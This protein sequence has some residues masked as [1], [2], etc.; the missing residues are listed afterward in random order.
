MSAEITERIFAISDLHQGEGVKSPLEDFKHHP[1]GR[2]INDTLFD[3]T[4]DHVFMDFVLWII[5]TSGEKTKNRLKLLGDT[6]DPLAVKL[7]GKSVVI[8]YEPLDL[9]KFRKICRGHREFFR[10]LRYFCSHENCTLEVHPGNHDMFLWWPRVQAEF[11]KLVSPDHPERV[12]FMH[13]ELDRGIYYWHGNNEP[14]DRFDPKKAIIRAA[15]LQDFLKNED[16]LELLLKGKIPRREVMDVPQGHY[17]TAWLENPL[18]EADYLIGRMHIHAFVWTDAFSHIF[19]RAWYRRRLFPAIALY[20]LLKTLL[21]HSLSMFTFWHTKTKSDFWKIMRVV[22]WT[23]TGAIVGHSARD[24][25]VKKLRDEENVDIVV[26]GHEHER[27]AELHHFGN[28]DKWYFNTGTWL[29]M[30]EP[31][32]LPQRKRWKRFRWIQAIGLFFGNF[33]HDANLVPI[34][35]FTVFA[36]SYDG[37]GN[38]IAGLKRFDPDKHELKD[39]A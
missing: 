33:F 25:A 2:Q 7:M 39:L 30:L 20:Y 8:P 21:L 12:K 32:A 35:L 28:R 17:L 36:V 15:E 18:K 4:L 9:R 29:E 5:R 3:Y 24:F 14:H 38:R 11:V 13:D 19:R 10:A 37:E 26:S 27:A 23:I 1:V 16:M 22:R 6:L 34:N 31:K